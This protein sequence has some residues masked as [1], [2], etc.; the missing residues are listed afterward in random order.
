MIY[1]MSDIHGAYNEYI[2]MKSKINLSSDDKLII[3]GDVIDRASKIGDDFKIL[4][5]IMKN[6]NI[7]LILGNHE[8]AFLSIYMHGVMASTS[9][10][11]RK[12]G[13]LK[14]QRR[15]I[16][17][18]TS[19][20]AKGKPNFEYMFGISENSMSKNDL[21]KYILYLSDCSSEKFIE[22][23]DSQ[24]YLTHGDVGMSAQERVCNRM[25]MYNK[26]IPKIVDGKIQDMFAYDPSRYSDEQREFTRDKFHAFENG[27][28][29]P[30]CK[31]VIGHTPVATI[32]DMDLS[33]ILHIGD[34]INIDCWCSGIAMSYRKK[35]TSKARLAC[36]RL[37]DMK[38]YYV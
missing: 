26:Y 11:D 12:E 10:G 17:Y 22:I 16:D 5:D 36:L 30:D 24:F 29:K 2:K 28:W 3:L 21:D 19:D 15:W 9:E 37:D 35:Y 1:V 18:I 14:I 20:S 25:D 38:E 23:E 13:F 7:E 31:I 8:Y 34:N 6:D 27:L 33:S 4:D 32:R